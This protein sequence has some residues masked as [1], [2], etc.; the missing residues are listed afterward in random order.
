MKN[1]LTIL[2][3]SFASLGLQAQSNLFEI[4][5]FL[6]GSSMG[7]DL[8]ESNF[9]STNEINGAYGLMVRRYF[10]PNFAV[11]VNALAT[12]LTS[13]DRHF[14]RFGGQVFTSETPLIEISADFEYD[15]LGHQRNW[16]GN[17]GKVSPYVFLGIGAALTDPMLT[18]DFE[19]DEVALDET[20]DISKTRFIMPFGVGGRYNFSS[21]G[22]IVLEI[23]VRPTFSDYLDGV[24]LA[25]NPGKN[26][27]YGFGSVQFWFKLGG[28]N[29]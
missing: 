23:G 12:K 17:G 18:Y 2:F 5:F 10:T 21:K 15:I 16:Q 6:G 3:F 29:Y 27:W 14:D 28:K 24:S 13:Q 8:V 11:R 9:G 19:S 4:G 25:G 22:S 20:A 1:L 26:D 7:G